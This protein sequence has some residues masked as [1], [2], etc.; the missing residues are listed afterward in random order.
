MS[1]GVAH[2]DRGLA[3]LLGRDQW[4]ALCAIGAA[5]TYR[6]GQ[7]LLRQGERG[8]FVLVLISGRV[9]VVALDENGA[10]LLQALRG[11]GDLVGEM[12]M[13]DDVARTAAVVALDRCEV[14]YVPVE[15]LRRFLEATTV[16]SAFTDYLIAKLSETVEYQLQLVNFSPR[17]RIARLMLDVIALAAGLPDPMRIPLS[18]TA[19]AAALGL[20]RSTVSEQIAV[21]REMGVLAR[22]PRL[23]VTDMQRLGEVADIGK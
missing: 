11:P 16:H 13:R 4:R 5:R 14:R 22:G 20:A 18:Q 3:A 15:R 1:Q 7:Y 6:Q 10:Q 2:P 19:I 21:M 17:Q 8:G 23:V 9:Q 12:A